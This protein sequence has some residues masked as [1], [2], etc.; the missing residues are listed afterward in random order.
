[1]VITGKG[2]EGKE[3]PRGQFCVMA[4]FQLLS[5]LTAENNGNLSKVRGRRPRFETGSTR[6]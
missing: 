2:R 3:D 6:L 4:L 5:I 1:M